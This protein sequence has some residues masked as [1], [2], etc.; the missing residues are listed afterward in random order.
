IDA[1]ASWRASAERTIGAWTLR[2]GGDRIDARTHLSGNVPARGGDLGGISGSVP[3]EVHYGDTVAGAYVETERHAGPITATLGARVQHF[4]LARD[5]AVDPRV[6]VA[7]DTAPHQ[8]ASFA[9]GEYRQAP[10]AAYY[11]HAGD[12]GL[13]AMR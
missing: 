2:L 9:W 3:I 5:T 7:V 4:D 6:N 10:D 1:I 11:S 13:R 12:A 8:K